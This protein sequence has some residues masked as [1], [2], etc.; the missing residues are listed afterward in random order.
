M[1]RYM[2]F[3]AASINMADPHPSK[4]LLEAQNG[5]SAGVTFCPH[6]EY[7]KPAAHEDQEGFF[8]IEGT[9]FLCMDGQDIPVKPD[10]VIILPPGVT[11]TFK[12]NA[13]SVPLKFFW[14]HAAV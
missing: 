14:F 10:T 7:G 13:D 11:H 8:V 5:C 2:Y 12:R 6:T 4:K 1:D 3:D 9:G